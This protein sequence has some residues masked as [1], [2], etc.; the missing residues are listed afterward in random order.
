MRIVG[1]NDL[2]LQDFSSTSIILIQHL[3]LP[4][5]LIT[6]TLN[7]YCG[8]VIRSQ[9]SITYHEDQVHGRHFASFQTASGNKEKCITS[10]NLQEIMDVSTTTRSILSTPEGKLEYTCDFFTLLL[11]N[12]NMHIIST[13]FSICFLMCQGEGKVVWQ[14]KTSCTSDHFLNSCHLNPLTPRSNF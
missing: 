6:D 4:R 9:F 1:Q 2:F 8:I 12:I 11:A 13:L 5:I 7:R 14:T 3:T 10:V